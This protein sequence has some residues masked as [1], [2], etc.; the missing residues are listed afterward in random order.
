MDPSQIPATNLPPMAPE[1][2]SHPQML[3]RASPQARAE[4]QDAKEAQSVDGLQGHKYLKGLSESALTL[5]KLQCPSALPWPGCQSLGLSACPGTGQDNCSTYTGSSSGLW[6]LAEGFFPP[7][8]PEGSHEHSP[9]PWLA[10]FVPGCSL[11]R[12]QQP[13]GCDCCAWTLR[14]QQEWEWEWEWQRDTPAPGT[15]C[16]Q[17]AATRD[18]RTRAPRGVALSPAC[19]QPCSLLPWQ[20]PAL[21]AG[22]S[23]D[24]ST[25]PKKSMG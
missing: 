25:L 6:S 2:C 19:H 18:G 8:T 13:E 17:G 5:C 11:G 15:A 16:T 24:F 7:S 20:S 3:S 22:L 12:V 4:Q 14:E 9:L 10:S 23:L 21:P 1:P